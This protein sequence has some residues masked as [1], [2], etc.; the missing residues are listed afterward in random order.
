MLKSA[1]Q[2][3]SKRKEHLE[4]PRKNFTVHD[5]IGFSFG[6][7]GATAD[8]SC[9]TSSSGEE[10]GDDCL[11]G[12]ESRYV[13]RFLKRTFD[14]VFSAAIL[15]CFCWLYALIA[16]LIKLDDPKGPI[17]FKQLRVGKN[18]ECFYMHKFRSMVVD[19]EDRLDELKHLN[20]KM[21]PVFKIKEDPRITKVGYWLRK[22]SLDELPQFWDVLKGKMSVVGPRP[23]L[24]AEVEAYT[25]YQK[26]RLLIK[27]GITCYWQTRTNRDS[28][29]FDEWVD[30]DLLYI[31]QCGIW[32]DVK[33]IIQTIGVVLTAQGQ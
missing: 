20:E 31:R 30:L 29:T 10:M 2:L 1:R 13:Y 27:P 22:L 6:R 32:T 16:L 14:V 28:I 17:I 9:H 4:E 12:L 18:G 15:I 3:N 19:A 25:N 26:Q 11:V 21:G 8:S 5:G 24:P 23:A 33:L 7:G